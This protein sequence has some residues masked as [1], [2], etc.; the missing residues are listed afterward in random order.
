MG[1][2]GI[3]IISLD[4]N[5]LIN[6]LNKAYADEWFAY[7]QYWVSAK[8]VRGI[9]RSDTVKEL[10]EHASEELGHAGKLAD[11]I[12]QLGGTPVTDME[13]FGKI[14][15]CSYLN[16]TDTSVKAIIEQGIAGERCAIEVY[17]DLLAITK[18]KD[19]VTN[20]MILE[21]LEDEIKHEADFVAL[22]ED[23]A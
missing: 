4:L 9:T 10:E 23:L 20:H 2:K 12:I 16:P 19:V 15:N 6:L 7:Y 14:A 1:K 5:E 17:N 18:G 21:I 3:D 8:I 11:R 22:L 13:N